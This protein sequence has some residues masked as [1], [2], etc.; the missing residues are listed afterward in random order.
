MNQYSIVKTGWEMFD[1]SRAYGLGILLYGLSGSDV[2]ICDKAYYFEISAP[3][4]RSIN[5]ANLSLFLADD[6]SWREVLL[7]AP[8]KGRRDSQKVKEMKDFLT[9]RESSKRISNLLNQ[10]TSFKPTGIP[11]PKGETLYQPMELRATKGLRNAVRL[12]KQYSEGESIKVKKDDW[13]LSCLGHLNVTVWKYDVL[14]RR[15][16]NELLVAMP[17]PSSEGTK[18][19][20]LLYQIKKDRIEKA[21]LRIHRAG[22]MPT[23]AYI[24][25]NITEAIL[26]LV[27]TPLQYKPRFSSILYGS[28]RATGKGAM[29]RWK[30]AT[31]GMFSLEYL[32]EIA[33]SSNAKLLLSFLEEIFR[34][35]DKTGYED[36]AE[37]L[38]RFLAD[39]SFMNF[40][41]YLRLHVRHSLNNE[42]KIPL[43]TK[44]VIKGV[45]ENV[46]S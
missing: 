20:H 14:P 16:S 2:Y 11:S 41:N 44:E 33:K 19:D 6:L 42:A 27:K 39:P 38:S 37:S 29:K 21:I 43:Y 10:Y 32:N 15:A 28:M 9:G 45:M 35:T 26:D 18:A 13:I 4:I 3:K 34:K 5:V 36:L 23:L 22:K 7:T 17:V 24:G 46:R 12:R 30:P 8:G 31:A 40:E 25:V 1:L